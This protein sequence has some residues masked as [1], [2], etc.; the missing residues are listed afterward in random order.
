M[1]DWKS[2]EIFS[3][4]KVPPDIPI[5]VRV[6]GWRFRKVAMELELEKPFDRRLIEALANIPVKLVE[7]GFPILLAYTFSDEISFV[8]H[9]PI[10][11]EGRVEK[12]VS[13]LA[14]Y[15]SGHLSSTFGRPLS[16]DGRIILV[17]SKEEIIDYL[18]WRQS[19][20][21]RNTINSYALKALE[22]DGYTLKEASEILKGAKS[23]ELHEIIF[24]KLGINVAKVPAWQRRGVIVKRVEVIKEESRAGPVIRRRTKIDWEPPLF[25]TP[26]GREYLLDLLST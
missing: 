6:D 4:L 20:A 22:E 12:V 24:N 8:L 25:S 17:R 21:W 19:E 23:K 18:T 9:P 5:V 1:I 15:S 26:E 11:W 16:F 7:G 14:S 13:I 10:P 2:R 3:S